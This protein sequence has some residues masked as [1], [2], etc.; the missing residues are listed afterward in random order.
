MVLKNLIATD[1]KD[2]EDLKPF[3]LCDNR[4]CVRGPT[5]LESLVDP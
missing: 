5:I 4:R 3:W 1:S 2:D